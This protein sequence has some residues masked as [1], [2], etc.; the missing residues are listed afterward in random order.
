VPEEQRVV[1]VCQH[2]AFRSRL[3]AAFFNADPPVGWHAVSSGLTPQSEVSTRLLPMLEGTGAEE[4]A[5]TSHPRALEPSGGDRIIA[6]DAQVDGAE[7]WTTSGEDEDVRDQIRERVGD[8]VRQLSRDDVP[9]HQQPLLFVQ[10]AG[11]MWEPEGSGVLAT[12]LRDE[13]GAAYGVVAPEMPDA[14]NPHYRPWRDRIVRELRRMAEPVLLVGHSF[15]GSVL[16][17]YLAQT[18]PAAPVRGL[19][20]VAVPFWGRA[21]WRD[22]EYALPADFSSRLPAVPTF[23][24]HSRED[25][26][27]PFAH[28]ALYQ[29]RLPHATYRVI[30]G[31]EH[32]FLHGLSALIDDIRAVRGST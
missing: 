22:G 19:F 26:H 9:G 28:L 20:L 8:L 14:A 25:P 24:Y 30:E 6:I 29:Q 16:L 4:S 11:D 21:G 13:L 15:G 32:S 17:K 10:G 23:L 1:F 2:G 5:D 18:E 12:Y 31:A 27:V 7:T 3:A